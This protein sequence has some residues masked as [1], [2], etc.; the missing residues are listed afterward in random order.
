MTYTLLKYIVYRSIRFNKLFAGFKLEWEEERAKGRHDAADVLLMGH[1]DFLETN[2]NINGL[3][4]VRVPKW[5]DSS[6]E[7][8]YTGGIRKWQRLKNCAV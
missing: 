7:D 2:K 8:A 5:L 3:A 1:R 6:C 4:Q